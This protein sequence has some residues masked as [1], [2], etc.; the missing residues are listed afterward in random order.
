[1]ELRMHVPSALSSSISPCRRLAAQPGRAGQVV[2]RPQPPR[3]HSV[4]REQGSIPG[5]QARR[6]STLVRLLNKLSHSW[7][8]CGKQ[9]W[10]LTSPARR[11]TEAGAL[12]WH[13]WAVWWRA[14]ILG[15]KSRN[16][17]FSVRFS[18]SCTSKEVNHRNTAKAL[19]FFSYVSLQR[20]ALFWG[21]DSTVSLSNQ[22][23]SDSALPLS[24]LPPW[25]LTYLL[26]FTHALPSPGRRK[27]G[28]KSSSSAR[29]P[30]APVQLPGDHHLGCAE[31][32]HGVTQL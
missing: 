18:F 16:F 2:M 28:T 3:S 30:H 6:A 20:R 27:T 31:L 22:A 29:N 11:S 1:M 8:C 26:P 4:E 14:G 21:S 7:L 32:S 25:P 19:A 23:F 24:V 15:Q 13:A 17:Y 10:D 12:P 5:F 9:R